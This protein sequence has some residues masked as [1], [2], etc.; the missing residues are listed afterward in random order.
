[1]RPPL[2]NGVFTPYAGFSTA[3]EGD[4]RTYRL[5]ARWR[6]ASEF[7]TALEAS[8]GGVDEAATPDTAAVIRV[9]HRW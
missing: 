5:G 8:H 1:M 7:H 9:E 4:G 3:G 6:G 2:G